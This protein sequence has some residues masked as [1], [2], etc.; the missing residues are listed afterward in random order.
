MGNRLARNL[1]EKAT[2]WEVTNES[3][4]DGI[5]FSAPTIIRCRWEDRT[6]LFRLL[7][8]EEVASRSI[9]YVDRDVDIGTY[10]AR[11]EFDG[12]SDPTTL[13]EAFRVRNTE[14]LTNLR[15]TE[16]ERKLFL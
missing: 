6:V 4:Y 14:K 3:V 9:V 12:V 15:N 10:I 11:G 16:M 13:P 2:I 7:T 5:S 1:R 8:G